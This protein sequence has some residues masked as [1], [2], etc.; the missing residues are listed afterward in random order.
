MKKT[1]RDLY[2]VPTIEVTEISIEKGFAQSLTADDD[3]GEM[4]WGNVGDGDDYF[5]DFD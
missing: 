1:E 5:G 2:L 4:T 3:L